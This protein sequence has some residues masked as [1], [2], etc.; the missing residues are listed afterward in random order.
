MCIRCII[1]LIEKKGAI[2]MATVN[3]TLRLEEADKKSAEQVFNQL[4]LS[5]AAGLNVYVKAVVRQKRIPFELSVAERPNDFQKA[6]YDFIA[7]NHAVDN[8][9]TPEDFT[10]FESGKYRL[11]S[12]ERVIDL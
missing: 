7:G 11:K 9:L 1:D 8:E 3:Y 2:I 5:L 6:A 10:E 4:G 12:E